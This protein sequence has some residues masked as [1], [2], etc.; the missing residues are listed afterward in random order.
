MRFD[1]LVRGATLVSG[2]GRRVAD[3]GI[4]DGRIEAVGELSSASAA[5]EL[6]CAGLHVLPG[7]I[8]SH[9]HLR[10]PGSEHKEDLESGT[11]AAV[12][13][14]VTAV[15]EMPNTHPAATTSNAILDKLRRAK[16]RSWCHH[17]FYVGATPTNAEELERFR[18]AEWD[19]VAGIKIFMASSTGDL[20]VPHDEEIRRVLQVRDLPV[21]VHSEDEFRL[22]E[23]MEAFEATDVTQHPIIRDAECA[24]RG[25]ERL[26]ALCA[27]TGRPVHILH[28]STSD[29]LPLIAEAKRRGV[30]VTAEICPQHLIFASPECYERLGSRVQQNPP[31]RDG[32]HRE[33]L[34]QALAAGLFDT[35][36]TDHAPHTLE[37]K[38]LPYPSS[39]SGMPG[40]QTLVPAMLNLIAEGLIPLE[41]LVRLACE[42][43]ARVFGARDRGALEP[44][45]AADLTIVD[46]D[47]VRT[48]ERSWIASRC[49][50]SPYEGLRWRGWP[51]HTVVGG[52]LAMRDCAL[53]G[54]PAGAPMPFTR[55]RPTGQDN[56]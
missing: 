46:L 39:P 52:A 50:W 54:A 17:A 37:E 7:V 48:V 29:E 11:R 1:L 6:E 14:G 32:S 35:V 12:L 24:R 47:A 34:R 55:V 25:T 8:D 33:A 40:V 5:V 21:V 20:L 45:F 2:T 19:G 56:P 3:I 30:K 53:V 22:R 44:G 23:R 27:E 15:F 13:G 49:G 31:I 18:G 51:I 38:A 28:V 4:T 43:P 9:V 16:G 42:G 41:Q 26:L 10:E 36:G